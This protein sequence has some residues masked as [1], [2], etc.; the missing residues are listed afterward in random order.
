MYESVIHDTE[1]IPKNGRDFLEKLR[2]RESID[3][4]TEIAVVVAHPDD[5]SIAFGAQLSR[6]PGSMMIHVTDGAPTDPKEWKQKGF[7]TQGQYRDTRSHELNTALD[8][9]GHT[10][11]RTSLGLSDQEASFQLVENAKR[12]AELFVKHNTKFVLTHS[13]E[14]GHPDHDATAFAVH[15]AKRLM[16]KE[17]LNLEIIEAPL[18]RG[19]T[20]G[21]VWQ[22]F[23]PSQDTET[24]KLQL[25][26]EDRH[27]K[28]KLFEAHKSQSE[29]FPKVSTTEEWLREAP[30][31]D[32]TKA[33]NEGILSRIFTTAGITNEKWLELTTTAEE[34]LGFK[35]STS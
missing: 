28:E 10:G 18:Y 34:A 26:E 2:A 33:P 24:F 32:F 14:G 3:A 30:N 1:N 23:V 4:S 6:F 5:E 22:S 7:E 19:G 21:S 31:Y 35:K 27:L 29:T 16:E 13:Y 25:T 12:L 15:A 20:S 8:I 9:A 11:L 17:G